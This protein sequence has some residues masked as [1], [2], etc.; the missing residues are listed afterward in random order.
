MAEFQ[1]NLDRLLRGGRLTA[2]T[3]L[4]QRPITPSIGREVDMRTSSRTPALARA[5]FE[6]ASAGPVVRGHSV[7]ELYNE[8]PPHSALRSAPSEFI[9]AQT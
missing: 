5:P 9:R 4:L 2:A 1:A 6:L 8:I 3:A 7:A